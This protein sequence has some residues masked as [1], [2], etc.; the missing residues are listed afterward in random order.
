MSWNDLEKI[1]VPAVVNRYRIFRR[2][3]IGEIHQCLA[4]IRALTRD[5]PT[6]RIASIRDGRSVADPATAS[7]EVEGHIVNACRPSQTE[8]NDARGRIVRNRQR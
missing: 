7:A 1:R 6:P 8:R 5:R 4:S 2:K 3:I